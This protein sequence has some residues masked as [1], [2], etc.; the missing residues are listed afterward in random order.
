MDGGDRRA[1]PLLHLFR[2]ADPDAYFSFFYTRAE[3][4][5]KARAF[6]ELLVAGAPER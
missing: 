4:A 5:G 2:H 3:R 1:E 6:F